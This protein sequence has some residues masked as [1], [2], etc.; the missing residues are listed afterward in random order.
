MSIELHPCITR[1]QGSSNSQDFICESPPEEG[2]MD[3]Y[4]HSRVA[5]PAPAGGPEGGGGGRERA[6]G[7]VAVCNINASAF[8][9]NAACLE[10]NILRR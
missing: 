9:R 1:G 7:M 6:K 2:Q 10:Y 5:A 8:L 3:K 4:L